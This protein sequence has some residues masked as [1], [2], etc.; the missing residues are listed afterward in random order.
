MTCTI[1]LWHICNLELRRNTCMCRALYTFMR[2]SSIWLDPVF[3]LINSICSH[4]VNTLASSK[5]TWYA[6]TSLANYGYLII[7]VFF[8]HKL[9][10]AIFVP[11]DWYLWWSWIFVRGSRW[12]IV[13]Y[14]EWDS[15]VGVSK[16]TW[17]RWDYFGRKLC[18]VNQ[19]LR[20]RFYSSFELSI[21]HNIIIV[22]IS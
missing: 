10:L 8:C 20:T 3:L 6:F 22:V 12:T 19:L 15:F 18:F 1:N 11:C 14:I 4:Q 21:Y 16:P 5:P 7:V 17:W 13:D 9:T 2:F